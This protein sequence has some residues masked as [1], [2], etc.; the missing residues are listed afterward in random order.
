[1]DAAHEITEAAFSFTREGHR[2]FLVNVMIFLWCL[3]FS[4][5]PSCLTGSR[6]LCEA[7]LMWTCS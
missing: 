5:L 1:M 4:S 3:S 7:P 6:K 2:K